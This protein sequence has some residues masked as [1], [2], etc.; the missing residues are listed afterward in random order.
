VFANAELVTL[1]ADPSDVPGFNAFMTF[2][3]GLPV[4]RAAADM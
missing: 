1:G 3:A 4:E 2:V